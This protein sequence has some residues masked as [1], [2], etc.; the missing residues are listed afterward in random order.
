MSNYLSITDI[1]REIGVNEKTVRRWIKSGELR[2]NKDIL[3]RYR[4]SRADFDDFLRRR[5][6]RFGI[7]EGNQNEDA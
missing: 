4:I 2:A 6:E 3:G 1:V 5:R 7:E